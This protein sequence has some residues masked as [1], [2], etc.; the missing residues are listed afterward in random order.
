MVKRLLNLWGTTQETEVCGL[1]FLRLRQM[2]LLLPAPTYEMCYK[3]IY[4]SYVR[5]AKFVSEI[6][7]PV[8]TFR[9]NCVVEFY[10]LDLKTAYQHAFVYIRQV[11]LH[12]RSA[13]LTKKK[14]SLEKVY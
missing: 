6:S 8:I 12:L 9:G 3:G 1:A 11:S 7:L 10:G 5:N 4:L 14:E 13:I 2:S